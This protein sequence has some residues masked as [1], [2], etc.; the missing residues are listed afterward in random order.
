M[1]RDAVQYTLN[2]DGTVVIPDIQV[3]DIA[4]AYG[5]PGGGTQY[6]IP[7]RTGFLEEWGWLIRK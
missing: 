1:D 4:P 7:I 3:G 6:Q 2:P 5:Q